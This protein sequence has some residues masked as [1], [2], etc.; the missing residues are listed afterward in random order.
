MG[1]QSQISGVILP[2][3]N[4]S[5][6][7]AV[8]D[9]AQFLIRK[10]EKALVDYL[11]ELS[12]RFFGM[13]T[14]Q[15]RRLAFEFAERNGVRHTFDRHL[16]MAGVDWLASFRKRHKSLQVPRSP[17]MTSLGRI[18]D[19]N[20][21][22]TDQFFS[23]L[24]DL[25]KKHNSFYHRTASVNSLLIMSAVQADGFRLPVDQRIPQVRQTASI[26]V[27]QTVLSSQAGLPRS[28][29]QG[30]NFRD[31]VSCGPRAFVAKDKRVGVRQ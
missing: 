29:L 13:T 18:Q 24:R 5:S 4:I 6:Q 27:Q 19:F 22:Q 30:D 11:L 14:E 9:F 31:E 23:L 8:V 25:Y 1:Y 21:A 15:V 17:E 2:K 20:E 26:K 28:H 16:R 12:N 10:K 7:L 3:K